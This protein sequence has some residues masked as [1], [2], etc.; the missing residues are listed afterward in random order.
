MVWRPSKDVYSRF[1]GG[2]EEVLESEIEVGK[3][4]R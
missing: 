3:R 1:D 4:K 2:C